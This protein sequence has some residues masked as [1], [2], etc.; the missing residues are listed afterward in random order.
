M[1][2]KGIEQKCSF[3]FPQ[4]PKQGL[5]II[6][7]PEL[8]VLNSKPSISCQEGQ[9][10]AVKLRVLTDSFLINFAQN[11]YLIIK[12]VANSYPVDQFDQLIR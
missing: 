9:R 5:K 6:T 2:E 7:L 8:I 3:N 10:K 12:I 1:N 11:D 4:S